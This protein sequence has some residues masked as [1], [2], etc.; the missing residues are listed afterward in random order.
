MPFP[1][2]KSKYRTH[3]IIGFVFTVIWLLFL[4]LSKDPLLNVDERLQEGI[5]IFLPTQSVPSAVVIVDIDDKSL[6]KIGQW[7]WPRYILGNLI[8]AIRRDSSMALGIDILFSEYDRTSLSYIKNRYKQE[9]D[10]DMAI[11]G[12]PQSMQDNDAYFAA[13]LRE[14]SPIVGAVQLA[15]H[16]AKEKISW[17][18]L[19]D[20]Q[21]T[22]PSTRSV[23]ENIPLVANAIS[24]QGFVNY[25]PGDDGVL[26]NLP[27]VSISPG[28][29]LPSLSLAMLMEEQNIANPTFEKQFWGY[30]LKAGKY[31]IPVDNHGR[32]WFSISSHTQDNIHISAVDLLSG[33]AHIPANKFILIGATSASLHDNVMTPEFKNV[34]GVD[35]HASVINSIVNSHVIIHPTWSLFWNLLI[36]LIMLTIIN[37]LYCFPVSIFKRSAGTLALVIFAL[38]ITTVIFYKYHVWLTPLH[39]IVGGLILSSLQEL[40]EY[41]LLRKNVNKWK[42]DLDSANY[43]LLHAIASVCDNRDPETGGHTY[44]TQHYVRCLATQLAGKHDDAM[45]PFFIDTLYHAAPLHDVGKVAIP[46]SIL[47]KPGSLSNDEYEIIKTHTV[48]GRKMLQETAQKL[49]S[50]SEFLHCAID[51]A[52]SHHERW[53]GKGY[54]EGLTGEA[55]PFSARVMAVADV[56]DALTSK[57]VYKKSMSHTQAINIISQGT[58][59]QFDPR[60]VK[61]FLACEEEMES[62]CTRFYN[63]GQHS[64]SNAS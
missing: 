24:R 25:F 42:E 63:E 21:L 22:L 11:D 52:G 38:I 60:V 55:I 40:T 29:F 54:P 16:P 27:I 64:F 8:R 56:Y 2:K 13:V 3:C 53:D 45:H 41:C 9:F 57:R 46:D 43:A 58:G 17:Q 32:V 12:V 48:I 47:L 50:P 15:L 20:R 19:F 23:I 26:R 30:T 61:A 44:R 28:G 49:R 18:T 62:I 1:N 33:K 7:P 10:L 39:A 51:M 36:C 34:S 4:C 59:T 6:L 31:T 14:E 37:S 35:A 5:N